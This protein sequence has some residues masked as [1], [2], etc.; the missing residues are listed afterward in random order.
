[1]EKESKE[2]KEGKES[3]EESASVLWLVSSS[4]IVRHCC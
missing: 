1:M 4:D 2:G 3:L